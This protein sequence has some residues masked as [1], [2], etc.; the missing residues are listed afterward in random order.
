MPNHN[1]K[2]PIT[3][4]SRNEFYVIVG[5][6]AFVLII[7]IFTFYSPNSLPN[8]NPVEVEVRAGDSVDQIIDSLYTK[9]IIPGKFIMKVAIMIKGAEKK[10][11]AGIYYIDRP[12]SYLELTDVLIGE[13]VSMQKKVT[14]PEGIEQPELASLLQNELKIDSAEFIGLSGSKTFIHSLNIDSNNLEGYL[15]PET[16]YF[17]SSSGARGVIRKLVDQQ[18]IIW[19]KKNLEQ[20]K[21]LKMNKHQLLTLASIIDGESNIFSEFATIS[22]VY[23]NR[24]RIGMALQADPT[25][26]YL[27]RNRKNKKIYRKDLAIDSKYNTY[28]YSGLPPGPI[29]NPGK[30]AIIAALFPEKNNFIFFVANGD[31]THSF[32]TTYEQH[33]NYVSKYRRWLRNQN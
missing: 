4:F 23:H 27:I 17:Y 14:I 16:Y 33:S 10:L 19:T 31:G 12:M 32:S 21:K 5:F 24:L 2:I 13:V 9:G 6:F 1:K 20:L 7:L 3:L 11:K 26:A 8:N 22:G 29:N 28:K 18:N 25:V 15:L 30:Q